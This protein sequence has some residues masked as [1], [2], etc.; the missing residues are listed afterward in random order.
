MGGYLVVSRCLDIKDSR[1][2]ADGLDDMFLF[3]VAGCAPRVTSVGYLSERTV[4]LVLRVWRS[5][6][7]C[8]D[9]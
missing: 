8:L 6:L 9:E 7:L 5:E 3:I 2:E 1:A 4:L